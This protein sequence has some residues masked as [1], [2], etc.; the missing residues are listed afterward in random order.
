MRI[1]GAGVVGAV[2]LHG[3]AFWTLLAVLEPEPVVDQ[4]TPKTEFQVEAFELDR[5]AAREAEPTQ[6]SAEARAPDGTPL[7]PGAI[8]RSRANALAAPAQVL[9]AA[10]ARAEA[11]VTALDQAQN[12]DA[13]PAAPETMQAA[14]F[15]SDTIPDSPAQPETL[16]AQIPADT[17]LAATQPRA[18]AVLAE[19]GEAQDLQARPPTPAALAPVTT[20]ATPV[21]VAVQTPEA[22]A[23]AVTP[24]DQLA[25]ADLNAAPLEAQAGQSAPLAAFAPDPQNVAA[26]DNAGASLATAQAE[27]TPTA[28][29]ALPDTAVNGAIPVGESVAQAQLAS[30]KTAPSPPVIAPLE[31]TAPPTPR[32][33]PTRAP[34]TVQLASVTG[35]AASLVQATPATA[36][37][38]QQFLVAAPV[39]SQVP[40]PEPAR[41][42][43]ATTTTAAVIAPVS[44]SV[45]L[46]IPASLPAPARAPA[47]PDLPPARPN[48]AQL[49]AAAPSSQPAPAQTPDAP[50]ATQA[51][52]A[53]QRLKA[54][55][56]FSGAEGEV[57][58]VSVAAFQS[59]MQPGD[60]T[61]AGDPLRD[62]VSALLAQV[63]CARLQ[64]NFDP[65]T[66]RLRVNGHIPQDDLRAPVLAA[67]QR[68]MGDS[69]TV[70][71]NILILPRPQCGALSG[72]NAVGL[73]QSTDRF[74]NPQVI[75]SDTHVKV[76]RF[77]KDQLLSFDLT[78]PDYDAFVYVDYF[79]ADG[80]VLHLS[81][82]DQVALRL[83]PAQSVFRIGIRDVSEQGLQLRIGPP[84]GQEIA[85]A[86]AA[87]VPLY[88]GLRPIIEPAGPYLEWLKGRVDELRDVT[89]DFK[90][91]WIYFFIS[92]SES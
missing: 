6:D 22:L 31:A 55:L 80:N 27:V 42:A 61:A 3:A 44:N 41:A 24:S 43:P 86:F 48:A 92:T 72:I 4:P 38:A 57:D 69:I 77:V 52:P 58:P 90:G 88:D 82:N 9:P 63:P 83:A 59:F 34:P 46:A 39:A 7:D 10:E 68:Q 84:Y 76:E 56:A 28:S 85:V 50:Q 87:S 35:V 62:G 37:L 49:A 26:L 47:T 81:P 23:L 40:A 71:D 36:Q 64:V 91:E 74:N 20:A 70:S 25:T 30:L 1:W 54:A 15:P 21:N 79:D 5:T 13:A 18:E 2:A 53:A 65:D 8:P 67:L 29:L 11:V 12:L 33:A 16:G 45:A 66:A 60:V 51:Q 75:G 14:A 78:A 89:P 17:A 19:P 73:P 32:L